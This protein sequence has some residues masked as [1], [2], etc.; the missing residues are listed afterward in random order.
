MRR[1]LRAL[2]R[3][4]TA[5]LRRLGET[6]CRKFQSRN[7]SVSLALSK[8]STSPGCAAAETSRKIVRYGGRTGSWA[9]SAHKLSAAKPANETRRRLR[10]RLASAAPST[11]PNSTAMYEM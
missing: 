3:S 7:D 1:E 5:A 11:I 2:G 4:D 10:G 8:N 6:Y 9:G